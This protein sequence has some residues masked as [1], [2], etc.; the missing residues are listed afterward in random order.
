MINVYFILNISIKHFY[1]SLHK[2][3]I[4]GDF[5]SRDEWVFK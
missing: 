1:I 5:L 4:L 2:H 3:V